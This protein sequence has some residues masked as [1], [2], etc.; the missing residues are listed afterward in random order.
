MGRNTYFFGNLRIKSMAS[1][2]AVYSKLIYKLENNA[3]NKLMN[4]IQISAFG[5]ETTLGL[6]KTMQEVIGQTQLDG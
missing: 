5:N 1:F 2:K 4:F 6:Y 3:N